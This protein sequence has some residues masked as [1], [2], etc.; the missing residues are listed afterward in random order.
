MAGY[1][2]QVDAKTLELVMRKFWKIQHLLTPVA[3]VHAG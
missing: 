2:T 3:D 1:T